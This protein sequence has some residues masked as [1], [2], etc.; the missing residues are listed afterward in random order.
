MTDFASRCAAT[1]GL[2]PIN[3]I[4]ALVCEFYAMDGNAAG[5]DLH[6]V[7]EDINLGDGSISWCRDEARKLGDENALALAELLLRMPPLRRLDVPSF[8]CPCGCLK[9]ERPQLEAD[10]ERRRQ[11]ATP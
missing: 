7:V 5:G 9:D 6:V 1:G 11:G 2:A 4:D 8:D 10:E 3:V